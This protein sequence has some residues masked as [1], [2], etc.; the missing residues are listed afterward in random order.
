MKRENCVL[1]RP[2]S[3]EQVAKGEEYAAI[4]EEDS[5]LPVPLPLDREG[6]KR[7]E[8]LTN[9]SIQEH[10]KSLEGLAR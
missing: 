3:F 2:G 8:Q 6:L 5:I 7:I 1:T 4:Q 9:R 10:R